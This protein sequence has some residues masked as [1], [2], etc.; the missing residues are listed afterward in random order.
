MGKETEE[1]VNQWKKDFENY[2]RPYENN[3]DD[4]AS[5]SIEKDATDFAWKFILNYRNADK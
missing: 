4:Y 2:N 3:L 5:Q 1:T